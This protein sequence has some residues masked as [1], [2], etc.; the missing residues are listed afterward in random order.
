MKSEHVK[1][2]AE[3]G[4]E[5]DAYVAKPEGEPIAGLVV[6]QE[7][8]GVNAHVRSVADGYA[9]DGF[10]AVAPALFDRAERGVELKYEG[11][12]ARRARLF[13]GRI[14]MDDMLRDTAVAIDYARSQSGRKAGIIGFCLGGSIAWIAAVR[15]KVDAAVAYY[16]G[17]I[18]EHAS[19]Q[20]QCPVML[21]F[22]RKDQHI[23]QEAVEKI[24][25][26]HPEVP[27]YLYD[28]GH[29]FNCDAR[30]SYDAASARLAR[31]RSLDFL[32][33]TLS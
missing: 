2:K 13:L 6:L 3:D 5:L 31:E 23:P 1:L 21:H 17:N 30:A 32:K 24:R 19:E 11:E 9:R 4:H 26:A 29:G 22:G 33:K 10:L 25:Q 27:I 28:A 16:G 14:K 8:F 12:D 7:I 18:P 20:P 15:F